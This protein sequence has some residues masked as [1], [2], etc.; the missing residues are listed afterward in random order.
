MSSRV[1][2]WPRPGR[3]GSHGSSSRASSSSCDSYTYRRDGTARRAS[4]GTNTN[5]AARRTDMQMCCPRRHVLNMLAVE[6][7]TRL[8]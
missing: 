1:A 8:P 5:D 6:G 2:A 7:E 3:G 4:V